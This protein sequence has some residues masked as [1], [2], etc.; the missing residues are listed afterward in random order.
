[1]VC[2]GGQ[3]GQKERGT[4]CRLSTGDSHVPELP[5]GTSS[6]HTGFTARDSRSV[7]NDLRNHRP[8]EGLAH[9][10]GSTENY[11]LQRAVYKHE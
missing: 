10:S 2:V 8:P 7:Q 6:P 3:L 9:T 5:P 1:M 11:S 4:G